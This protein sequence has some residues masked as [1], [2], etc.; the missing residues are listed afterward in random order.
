MRAVATGLARACARA[1]TPLPLLIHTLTHT[2]PV[3]GYKS[4][5]KSLRKQLG[6]HLL[7]NPDVVKRIVNAAALQ[8]HETVLEIGPGTGNL[9]V[10][11][12]EQARAVLAVE[13]DDRMYEAV[14]LRV[15]HMYAPFLFCALCICVCK[16]V[17]RGG[18][19]VAR[20][21]A[22]SFSRSVW[23]WWPCSVYGL[24]TFHMPMYAYTTRLCD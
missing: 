3:R 21:L 9:T 14:N 15:Q 7:K 20:A 10:H 23:L 24:M 18:A 13:L 11:M 4:V 5:L 22:A 2:L 12:L 6:Q 8:P 16:C 19:E 1:P 17:G